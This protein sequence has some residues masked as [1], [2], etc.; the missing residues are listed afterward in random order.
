MLG[1]PKRF[2]N[3]DEMAQKINNFESR[4]FESV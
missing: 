3:K 4:H 1:E 2:G